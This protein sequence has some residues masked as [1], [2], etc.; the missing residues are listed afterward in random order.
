MSSLKPPM[1]SETS[2]SN[3]VLTIIISCYN[4][5]E[6]TRDC[7]R[8]IYENPPRE[9]YEIILVDD[10]SA[11]GTSEMVREKVSLLSCRCRLL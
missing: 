7:L 9:A 8:S 11:D 3:I 1:G 10:A 5:L 6:L 2:Y 4:T